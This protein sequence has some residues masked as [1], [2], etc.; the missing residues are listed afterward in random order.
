MKTLQY[1]PVSVRVSDPNTFD[2]W[3]VTLTSKAD[4]AKVIQQGLTMDD[5]KV[6][7]RFW[8]EVL[9]E[10]TVTDDK[11]GWGYPCRKRLQLE[12]HN[13]VLSNFLAVH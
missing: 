7:I 11:I 10:E 13:Q 3:V 8:D 4:C 5:D 6:V 2:R 9:R 12:R 1:D